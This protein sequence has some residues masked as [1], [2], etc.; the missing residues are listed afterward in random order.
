MQ[1]ASVDVEFDDVAVPYERQRS[2]GSSLRAHVQHHGSVRS[3]THPGIGHADHVGYASGKKLRRQPHVPNLRH[4]RISL[5]AAVLQ[6]EYGILVDIE[7]GI[8]DSF[9]I[10]LNRPKDDGAA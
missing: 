7:I 5:G 9:F 1:T 6:N 2:A 10:M 3:A 8:A 4:S